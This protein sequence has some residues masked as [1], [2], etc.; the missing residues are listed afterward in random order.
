MQCHLAAAMF[1]ALR[2]CHPSEDVST[3][4]DREVAVEAWLF[5]VIQGE[6]ELQTPGGTGSVLERAA[7]NDS[8]SGAWWGRLVLP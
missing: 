2:K 7:R 4:T 3:Q 1:L 5:Q 6:L 8:C